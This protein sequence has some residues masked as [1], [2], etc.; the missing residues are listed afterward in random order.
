MARIHI[1]PQ[2]NA[3]VRRA[4]EAHNTAREGIRLGLI[5]GATTWLWLAGIDLLKGE[6]FSTFHFLGG[7][8]GFTVIHFTLCIGYGLTI[9]GAVHAS[10]KEPTV[11]FAIIF[12]AILFEAA[13]VMLTAMLSNIGVGD[14]AWG[15]FLVGNFIATAL[16]L[17]VI[18][19]RHS[20]RD[21]YHA[22]EA[23]QKN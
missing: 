22:A 7:L 4:P 20:L 12:C 10:M 6:P 13:F 1:V 9:I 23:L 8:A 14:P 17:A 2:R 19:R 5:V 16:T 18:T 21:L 15:K 3:P 11:M